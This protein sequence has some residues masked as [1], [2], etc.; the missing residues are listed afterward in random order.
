MIDETRSPDDQPAPLSP[1]EQAAPL[2]SA[3][4]P[5]PLSEPEQTVPLA[6]SW[7]AP[8]SSSSLLSTPSAEPS[9][10][11][12]TIFDPAQPSETLPLSG[13][14][15]APPYQLSD[16]YVV[17]EDGE[18]LEIAREGPLSRWWNGLSRN[19][20]RFYFGSFLVFVVSTFLY[21]LGVSAVVLTPA[22]QPPALAIAPTSTPTATATPFI[23]GLTP[24]P[25]EPVGPTPTFGVPIILLPTA[26]PRVLPEDPDPTPTPLL[27][28]ATPTPR[29][30]LPG[31]PPL[32]FSTPLSTPALPPG[33]P[34]SAI[35]PFPPAGGGTTP[36]VPPANAT[37][38]PVPTTPRLPATPPNGNAIPTSTP[39][40]Q[41]T[42]TVAPPTA[43]VTPLIP[44]LPVPASPTPRP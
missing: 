29:A 7:P 28:T 40:P 25:A 3:A 38:T 32:P 27:P 14:I 43:T 35:P 36:T 41:P 11:E 9:P 19:D 17:D 30:T 2:L 8:S 39:I 44:I 6:A 26:T 20:R 42:R 23:V 12:W 24:S 1:T 16:R 34:T 22:L 10:S 37:F 33:V 13:D 21:C 31:L 5:A 18:L 4:E 15:I